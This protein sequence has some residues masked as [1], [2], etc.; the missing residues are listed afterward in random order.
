MQTTKIGTSEASPYGTTTEINQQESSLPISFALEITSL[1]AREFDA[2]ETEILETS[3]LELIELE[4][5]DSY[6]LKPEVIQPE[7]P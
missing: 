5:L 3:L 4:F 6:A 2:M 7:K 1:L